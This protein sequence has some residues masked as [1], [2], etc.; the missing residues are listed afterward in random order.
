MLARARPRRPPPPCLAASSFPGPSRDATQPRPPL[1]SPSLSGPPSPSLLCFPSPMTK[2][3]RRR[4]SQPPWPPATPRPVDKP[5]RTAVV[6]CIVYASPF[7]C[8]SPASLPM[9]SPPSPAARDRRRPLATS[10]VS[11]EP[12]GLQSTPCKP[13]HRSPLPPFSFARSGRRFHQGRNPPP[14]KLDAGVT[15]VT[16]WSRTS[17]QRTRGCT[18]SMA[19]ALVGS[20]A[21]CITK[22]ATHPSAG[23]RPNARRRRSRPPHAQPPAPL[24]AEHSKLSVEPSRAP[25]RRRTAISEARRRVLWSPATHR[26]RI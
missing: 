16:I 13:R 26:R 10:D 7:D 1:T 15:P 23:R 21:R 11:P 22:P 5:R 14:H 2:S 8:G 19:S 3:R 24:D 9:P 12:L 25:N 6:S 20:F 4:R 17:V 18:Q